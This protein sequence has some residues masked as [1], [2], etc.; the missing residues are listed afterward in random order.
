V[1]LDPEH[2]PQH[3]PEVFQH[4]FLSVPV[5]FTTLREALDGW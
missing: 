3:S 5:V 4:L 1:R 2:P